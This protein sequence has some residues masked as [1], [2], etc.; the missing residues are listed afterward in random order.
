MQKVRDVQSSHFLSSLA[1]DQ[2]VSEAHTHRPTIGSCFD[3]VSSLDD[4]T[5]CT[6]ISCIP[7]L[8]LDQHQSM[9]VICTERPSVISFSTAS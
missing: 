5:A 4:G 2:H 6:L 1:L 3:L 9:E 8:H 7:F